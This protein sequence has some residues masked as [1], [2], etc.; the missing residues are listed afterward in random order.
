MAILLDTV[1]LP[2]ADRHEVFRAAM[3]DA[4]GATRVELEQVPGG[5]SGRIE[6]HSLGDT[7]LFT[8]QSSGM[9]L[10]RDSRTAGTASPEAVAIAVHGLGVGRH[11]M[12]DRQRLVRAGDVMVVDVTRPFDFSWSGLG[13]STSLQIPI[14][15]LGMP[16]HAVQK[17]AGRLESSALYGIVS[18]YLVELTRNADRLSSSTSAPSL[19]EASVQLI[20]A[21]LWGAAD[22]E[23]T[24]GEVLE[25]TLLVQVRAY[26]REHLRDPGLN[27]EQVALALSVSRRQLF[28]ACARADF[29][30]EQYVIGMRLEGA[31][32]ALGRPSGRNRSIASVAYSWGFKDATHFTR[33]FKAAYGMLPRE[34][35]RRAEEEAVARRE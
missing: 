7:R 18:R 10:L 8:A 12:G 22:D 14:A 2:A 16:L 26:A 9:A 21:L 6:L 20:R 4:S 33:R 13:S 35:R 3:L 5:V 29:S 25:Q 23:P 30:L 24:P 11:Q 19:G 32:S 34:W 17:A 31:K 28:R 27:A 1:R 15:E